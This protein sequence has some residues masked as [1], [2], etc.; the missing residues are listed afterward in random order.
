MS[1]GEYQP[2]WLAAQIRHMEAD[3]RLGVGLPPKPRTLVIDFSSP[4]VAKPMHVGHLRSTIIGDSLARLFRF[5]GHQVITDNHLGDMA[6][7]IT[8]EMGSPISFSNLAQAPAS[9]MMLNAFITIAQSYPWEETRPGVFGEVIVRRRN[10]E[11]GR[12]LHLCALLA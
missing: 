1:I 10:G 9:W 12:R 4:N 3:D 6:T 8:E 2:A 7:V 11:G 5:L